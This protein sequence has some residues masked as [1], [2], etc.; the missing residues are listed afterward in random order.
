VK[1]SDGMPFICCQLSQAASRSPSSCARLVFSAAATMP[2]MGSQASDASVFVS[3]VEQG[4]TDSLKLM[5]AHTCALLKIDGLP[6][7]AKNLSLAKT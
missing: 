3:P 7:E 1:I 4:S 2:G 6:H 5:V